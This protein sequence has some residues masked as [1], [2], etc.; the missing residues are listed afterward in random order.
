MRNSRSPLKWGVQEAD[1]ATFAITAG[2]FLAVAAGGESR[3]GVEDFAAGP[4]GD[5]AERVEV[6]AWSG[7]RMHAMPP[8]E[9]AAGGHR[10]HSYEPGTLC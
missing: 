5:G 9:L 10:I 1:P 8:W 4:G 2:V 6:L 3:A 7:S